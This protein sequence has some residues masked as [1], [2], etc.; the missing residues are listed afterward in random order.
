LVYSRI[1]RYYFSFIETSP[2]PE[3]DEGEEF[4]FD[5]VDDDAYVEL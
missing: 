3:N 5:V 1:V 2:K 4:R